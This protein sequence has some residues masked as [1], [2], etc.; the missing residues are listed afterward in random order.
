[1]AQE[2]LRSYLEFAKATAW[3]AGRLTL[4]YFQTQTARPEFKSDDS[5]VTQADQNAERLIRSRIEA[6]YPDHGL[7]G[8]E[9][10]ESEGKGTHRWII[11]PIDGTKSFICGVPIYGVLLALE[12][13]GNCEVGVAYFPALDDMVS[14]ATGL[15]ADWNGRA[16]RCSELA[17]LDRAILAHGD[18]AAFANND[19]GPAWERLQKA[20]YYN[21][22]W[23]DPYGYFL[24]AP[25]R[26]HVM[27]DPIMN[28]WDCG[29]FQPIFR[30]A[31]G[32]FGDWSGN[33]TIDGG[34]ALGTTAALKSQ[35]LDVVN[36]T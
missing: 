31:G 29:P 30:E 22:G 21:A 4:G 20:V 8:E 36:Q 12:I 11:D 23:C 27:L 26:A 34:E 19:K 7:V 6:A 32:Y 35:V 13:E 24:V 25:G 10:G 1:M 16:C 18:T 15:G 5:P 9:Y 2:S 28:I 33:E 3:E 14:A 17:D